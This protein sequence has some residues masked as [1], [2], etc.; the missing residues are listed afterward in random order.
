MSANAAA[1]PSPSRITDAELLA[2]ARQVLEFEARAVRQVPLHGRE[3]Q[4]FLEAVHLIGEATTLPRRGAVVVSGLGKSGLIGQKISAT[5]ASTGTPSHF[6]HPVEAVHGDLGRVRPEDVVLLLSYSGN[7][8]EC[9]ALAGLLAQDQVRTIALVGRSNSDLARLCS[10][11]LWIGDVDEAC[12]HNLAPT[13]S[14][15][16]TLA[17]GDALALAV[18]RRREFRAEDFHR[19]HPGGGL[20]RQ[21]TPVLSAMRFRA[22]GPEANL[23]LIL[24]THSVREGYQAATEGAAS[25]GIRRAG[26]LVV[27]DEQGRLAGIFTDGDL[28]RLVFEAPDPRG[29]D[30]PLAEVMTRSPILLTQDALVRDAVRVIRER[31]IDEVPVVDT[32]RRPLGLIDVQDLVS[33]KVIDG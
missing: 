18:S 22:V 3:S 16:A 33:L 6:L 28:R 11:T 32:D 9:V 25:A 17:L 15:T 12:P 24:Q 10:V 30:R 31:R 21:M 26:A 8:E 27:V 2:L 29:L 7:T 23:P 5:F 1:D 20:G 14:T 13:A 19:F 4:A